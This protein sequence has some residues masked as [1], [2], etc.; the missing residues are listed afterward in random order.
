MRLAP[1]LALLA[2]APALHAQPDPTPPE[3]YYPLAAGSR[4]EYRE[5]DETSGPGTPY[6]QRRIVVRDTLVGGETWA[7]LRTQRFRVVGGA[8]GPEWTSQGEERR[9]VRFDAASATVVQRMPGGGQVPLVECR[10]D[11]PLT[12]DGSVACDPQNALPEYSK[13]ADTE[14]GIPTTVLYV[15][16]G[17]GGIRLAAG[18]GPVGESLEVRGLQLLYANVGGVEYGTPI[19]GMP[20]APD[21]TPPEAYYPLAVGNEWQYEDCVQE[22]G[23]CNISHEYVRRTVER[24]TVVAG[25]RY[26]VEVERRYTTA[27]VPLGQSER[28]LRFAGA[29]LVRRDGASDVPV[30]C[31]LDADFDAT[32]DC[33]TYF[34]GGIVAAQRLPT[35]KEYQIAGDL[36]ERFTAGIGLVHRQFW[37]SPFTLRFARVGGAVVFGSAIVAGETDAAPAAVLTLR[38][39][40]NPTAG[41]L[42]LTLTLSEAKTVAVEAFDALGRRVWQQ[43]AVLTAGSQTVAVDASAWAP[44]VYVVR[45]TA[46]RASATARVVRR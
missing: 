19:A 12:G 18:I 9:L 2:L 15:S 36:S 1:L 41:A 11:G 13:R 24:E 8:G 37:T 34:G 6:R 46:G 29:T 14:F 31:P 22:G 45:A 43:N 16:T 35:V 26:F 5:T 30:S 21:P 32:V 25:T 10:L 40:P 7:V 27:S 33:G 20:N 28:L 3:A 42:V 4:W 39:T 38:A 44:G 23:V 17:M